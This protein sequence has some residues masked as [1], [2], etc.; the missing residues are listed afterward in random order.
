MSAMRRRTSE[1][2]QGAAMWAESRF[3]S[4]IPIGHRPA[5]KTSKGAS[6][7]LLLRHIN[8][9]VLRRNDLLYRDIC[10]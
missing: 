8:P 3:P 2:T 5:G 10:M 9:P 1:S 7:F 6:A 4:D